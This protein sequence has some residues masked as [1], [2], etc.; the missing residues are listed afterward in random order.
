MSDT[1]GQ[2]R[3]IPKKIRETAEPNELLGKDLVEAEGHSFKHPRRDNHRCRDRECKGWIHRANALA[4]IEKTSEEVLKA[5]KSNIPKP[6]LTLDMYD[7]NTR[8]YIKRE[9]VGV[10]YVSDS[11]VHFRS[12]GGDSIDFKEVT[13]WQKRAGVLF[14]AVFGIG[15]RL[16]IDSPCQYYLDEG[17]INKPGCGKG[18]PV[19]PSIIND[20]INGYN[21][22]RYK[23]QYESDMLSGIVHV[24]SMSFPD[25]YAMATGEDKLDDVEKR[26]I[27]DLM[28]VFDHEFKG[29]FR[30][31]GEINLNKQALGGLSTSGFN[32][33]E[34]ARQNLKEDKHVYDTM[35]YLEEKDYPIACHSDMGRDAS[36][37]PNKYPRALADAPQ[38]WVDNLHIID[39]FASVY[40]N[41]KIRWCHM[42]L[43]E[44]LTKITPEVHI[45]VVK[46]MLS[47]H[48]NMSCDV[49]WRVLYENLFKQ[50]EKASLY[51]DLFNEFPDRFLSGTDFIASKGGLHDTTEETYREDLDVTGRVFNTG[52]LNDEAFRGIVL[53]QNFIDHCGL[54]YRAPELKK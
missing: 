54:P 29:V 30:M 48:R 51:I 22:F 9:D 44:E 5:P 8:V 33:V 19:R 34:C 20:V 46:S 38:E 35:S 31:V 36:Q 7:P 18:E 15:Q 40:P 28:K 24:L 2:D 42:G 50:P 12:F 1:K 23:Y 25:L 21:Y 27:V 10:P 3:G 6:Y 4:V 43:S 52:G 53:G 14:T 16:P 26:T 37:L 45:E 32:A 11:H 39:T 17:D 13:D 47:K 41:N 49:S